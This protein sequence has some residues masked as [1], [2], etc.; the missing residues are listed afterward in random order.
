MSN[1]DFTSKE[2]IRLGLI[3][4]LI[5]IGY[6]GVR[7]S[8]EWDEVKANKLQNLGYGLLKFGL[9]VLFVF[10]KSRIIKRILF[11]RKV[12]KYIS[13]EQ[14]MPLGFGRKINYLAIK[15]DDAAHVKSI[16]FKKR[17]VKKTN[18]SKGVEGAYKGCTFISPPIDNWV[19]VL[20]PKAP[21]DD[22]S[23]E[24][25]RTRLIELSEYFEE[26]QFYGNHRVS[27]YTM[28]SKVINKRIERAFS[29]A[30]GEYYD[31][32]EITSI[33]KEII[34][35]RRKDFAVDDLEYS[36][37]AKVW[38]CLGGNEDHPFEIAEKWSINPCGLEDL[39]KDKTELGLIL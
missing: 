21:F 8:I 6:I 35:N 36:K 11:N 39:Y 2:M 28:W 3:S 14:D 15:S 10:L 25:C 19:F 32:G 13:S 29:Y 27:G 16:I 4:F 23:S 30:D 22:V 9:I 20:N 24:N 37:K 33:E 18:W 5:L 17:L 1:K 38:E 7:M 12:K 26:I 34:K 31:L